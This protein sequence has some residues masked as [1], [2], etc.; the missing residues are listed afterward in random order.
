MSYAFLN[1]AIY[2]SSNYSVNYGW[3]KIGK[4]FII[5]IIIIIF[6]G[7]V[8]LALFS[9]IEANRAKKRLKKSKNIF[10]KCVLDFNFAPITGRVFFNFFQKVKFVVPVVQSQ[11]DM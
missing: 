11:T 9:N 8:I 5:I 6:K 7:Q 3:R 2:S 1:Y 4:R 10:Y